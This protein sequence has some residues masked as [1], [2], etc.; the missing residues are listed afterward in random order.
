LS[1]YIF[2]VLTS[3]WLIAGIDFLPLLLAVYQSKKI[4]LM[5]SLGVFKYRIISSANKSNLT[6]SFPIWII[7][8]SFSYL[9]ALARNSSTIL[10]K[11]K[12]SGH[13][14]LI[15]DFNFLLW[16]YGSHLLVSTLPLE[17]L[18]QPFVSDLKRNNFHFFPF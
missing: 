2:W 16:W 1:S 17:L 5:E 13:P 9:I 4:F 10:N 14:C 3:T 7:F 18:C 15:P 8:I 12:E 11:S 6:S